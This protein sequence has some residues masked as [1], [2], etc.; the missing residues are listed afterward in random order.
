MKEI[1]KLLGIF[2]A[3][4]AVIVAM[5]VLPNSIWPDPDPDP[6]GVVGY[7]ELLES[8]KNEWKGKNWDE[9]LYRNHLTQIGFK[10][11]ELAQILGDK[12]AKE[13]HDSAVDVLKIDIMTDVLIPTLKNELQD[14]KCNND[15][16]EAHW[17][18]LNDFKKSV[19]WRD[20]DCGDVITWGCKYKEIRKFIDEYL[21]KL[22][23]IKI[24]S[25]YNRDSC[26]WTKFDD[27]QQKKKLDEVNNKKN[28]YI[29]ALKDTKFKNN[30]GQIKYLN[31]GLKKNV[32][33]LL[34]QRKDSYYTGVRDSMYNH[35]KAELDNWTLAEEK[36]DVI[37]KNKINKL[38]AEYK[39]YKE[40]NNSQFFEDLESLH[41]V[42]E[43]KAY[44]FSLGNN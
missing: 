9:D 30:I 42:Y 39:E 8:L 1:A 32:D 11:S 2:L 34:E 26:S 12:K 35:F 38:K 15:V 33:S 5:V 19:G 22:D 41:G 37:L 16:F 6:K 3:I 21:K 40:Y 23:G 28:R 24:P 18:K 17:K 29:A 4:V 31:D 25:G 7:Q 27:L 44:S 14:S 36:R 43:N 13:A 10:Y 20:S